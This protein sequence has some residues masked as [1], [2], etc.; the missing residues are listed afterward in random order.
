MAYF[1]LNRALL[2][3]ISQPSSL[4]NSQMLFL[5]LDRMLR[6]A[7]HYS[8]FTLF[9]FRNGVQ[10]PAP[11]FRFVSYGVGMK[12][13]QIHG[14]RDWNCLT[15]KYE[16]RNIYRTETVTKVFSFGKG[17]KMTSLV[18]FH[19]HYGRRGTK[20][21]WFLPFNRGSYQLRFSCAA[22]FCPSILQFYWTWI[23]NSIMLTFTVACCGV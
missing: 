22:C 12:F 13:S 21:L 10:L 23:G 1:K 4:V 5:S 3:L 17:K 9:F 2:W 11:Q 19:I 20:S 16:N 15:K 18:E 7:F 6:V 14:T 8:S